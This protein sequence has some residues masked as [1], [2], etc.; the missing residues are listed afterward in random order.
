MYVLIF[1]KKKHQKDFG[2][3]QG[4]VGK[5][6][7]KDGGCDTSLGMTF[8]VVLTFRTMNYFIKILESKYLK[9]KMQAEA[10]ILWYDWSQVFLLLEK[11]VT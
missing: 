3:F 1:T 4:F 8:S 7:G 2:Y 9:N 5:C 11:G 10:N 6:C